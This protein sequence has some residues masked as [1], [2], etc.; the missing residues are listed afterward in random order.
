MRL[1]FHGIGAILVSESKFYPNGYADK[2]EKVERTFAYGFEPK[3]S[4]DLSQYYD[5]VVDN[6]EK[7]QDV[8]DQKI[9]RNG[10]LVKCSHTP[11]ECRYSKWLSEE[12]RLVQLERDWSVA[13][14]RPTLH[15]L[16][17]TR[18]LGD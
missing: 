4:K 6:L 17:H 15:R 12:R 13:N 5:F 3:N 1:N 18:N 9:L 14:G 11:S 7:L 8:C 16:N 2:L 10:A